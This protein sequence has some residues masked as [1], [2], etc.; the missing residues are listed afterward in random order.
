[1][2]RGLGLGAVFGV[3]RGGRLAEAVSAEQQQQQGQ[4][5]GWGYYVGLAWVEP[6][7]RGK[8]ELDPLQCFQCKWAELMIPLGISNRPGKAETNT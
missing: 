8:T 4:E 5:Q 2:L 6:A 1:M 3:L 7:G